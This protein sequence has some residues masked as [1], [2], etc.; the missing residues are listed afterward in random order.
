[1]TVN[2]I[3]SQLKDISEDKSEKT[4]NFSEEDLKVFK[5]SITKKHYTNTI[6]SLVNVDITPIQRNHLEKNQELEL[7][8]DQGIIIQSM[9]MKYNPQSIF[10]SLPGD[11]DKPGTKIGKSR[12]FQFEI[13]GSKYCKITDDISKGIFKRNISYFIVVHKEVKNKKSL[14]LNSNN[15]IFIWKGE[16]GLNIT[17]NAIEKFITTPF[18]EIR[19]HQGKD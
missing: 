1:M 12:I 4:D 5:N 18:Q 16:D 6:S 15:T 2:N 11:E 8:N 3:I 7:T 9:Q 17:K 19:I 14:Y 10:T 13:E